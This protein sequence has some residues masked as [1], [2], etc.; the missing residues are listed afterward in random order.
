GSVFAQ[1]N[2]DDDEIL[3]NFRVTWIP[4]PGASLYFVLNQFGDTLN[5]HAR[6]RVNNTVA[7]I[8][9]VWYFST[10]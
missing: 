5:P 10:K 2:N 1:W 7:L 8:K 9:F 4:K 3:F 6:I